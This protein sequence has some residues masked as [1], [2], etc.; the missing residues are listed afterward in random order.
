M[1]SICRHC[2]RLAN[3]RQNFAISI[4]NFS[5]VRLIVNAR[6]ISRQIK[7]RFQSRYLFSLDVHACRIKTFGTTF[8]EAI[9]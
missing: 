5:S 3:S 2:E 7:A 1:K 6:Q 4:D 9:T 8:T